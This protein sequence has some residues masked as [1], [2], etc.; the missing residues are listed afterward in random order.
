M[1]AILLFGIALLSVS[2]IA[3][4]HHAY[5]QTQCNGHLTVGAISVT[6]L[7]LSVLMVWL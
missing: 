7:V 5:R 1:A 4:C 2:Q 3:L 6:T